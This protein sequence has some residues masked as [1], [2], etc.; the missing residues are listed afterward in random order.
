MAEA[1]HVSP[2]PGA[3]PAIAIELGLGLAAVAATVFA[4]QAWLAAAPL[5]LGGSVAAYL[6]LAAVIYRFWPRRRAGF[7]WPNRITLARAALVTVLVGALALPD[8]VA[9]HGEIIAALAVLAIILDGLDGWLAR[10]VD[11]V[12]A[13]G[14]RFDMEVDALL[15]LVLSAS[16]LVSGQAGAWVLAIGLMRYAFVAAGLVRPWWRRELPENAWRKAVCVIQGL[17]LAAALLP[18]IRPPMTEVVLAAALVL[19]AHSFA[20]DAMWLFRR[21][22]RPLPDPP[23]VNP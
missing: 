12:T 11:G 8:I 17:A 4:L 14:A 13:F 2:K 22:G 18:W 1:P 5:W 21:R 23:G 15:I 10:L 16:V 3:K 9:R 7:G 20:R 19:L 6:A